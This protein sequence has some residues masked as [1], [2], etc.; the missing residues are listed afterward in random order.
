M[1]YICYKKIDDL[2]RVVVPKEIR[3]ALDIR[4]NETVKFDVEGDKIVITK[5]DQTCIFCG[6]SENLK[7]YK[8]KTVCADCIKNLNNY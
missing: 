4:L 5:A 7:S 8:G 3:E 2:G 6:K 1:H